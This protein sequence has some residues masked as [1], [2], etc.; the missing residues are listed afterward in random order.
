M[1]LLALSPREK[2]LVE[3]VKNFDGPEWVS[4]AELCCFEFGKDERQW[5]FNARILVVNAMER[6]SRKLATGGQQIAKRGGRRIGNEY[7]YMECK[8]V[9]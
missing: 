4:T 2:R 9:A 1:I 6:A 7:K 5:P 8:N 3:Y